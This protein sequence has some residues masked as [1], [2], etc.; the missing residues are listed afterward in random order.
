MK[1]T[2]TILAAVLTLQSG[3]LFAGNEIT[4]APAARVSSTIALAPSV[5]MEVTFEDVATSTLDISSLAPATPLE[6]D[7]NDVITEAVIDLATLAPMAPT[8][9]DFSDAI[10]TTPDISA[11]S[12]AAPAADFE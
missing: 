9:A 4:L 5:P 7:F 12:P 10:A 8:T 1:T 6:A 2:M 3:I 11:L